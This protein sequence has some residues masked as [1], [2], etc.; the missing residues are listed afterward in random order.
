[1]P[2]FAVKQD[3]NGPSILAYPQMNKLRQ[4]PCLLLIILLVRNL[5]WAQIID[6]LF[7]SAGHVKL[8]AHRAA[9]R[10]WV[11]SD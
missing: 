5:G 8:D 11:A 7:L 9:W 10:V 4:Q 1:M 3:T 6:F 2:V